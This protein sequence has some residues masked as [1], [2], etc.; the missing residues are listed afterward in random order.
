MSETGQY[1]PKLNKAAACCV[2]MHDGKERKRM[3][4]R[5]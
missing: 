3:G 2:G 5:W 1:R 4:K